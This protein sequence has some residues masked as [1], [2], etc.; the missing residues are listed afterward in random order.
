MT[1]FSTY[2]RIRKKSEDPKKYIRLHRAEFG[3]DIGKQRN[4]KNNYYPDAKIL[5]KK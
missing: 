4:F 5:S 2:N 1:K 3:H